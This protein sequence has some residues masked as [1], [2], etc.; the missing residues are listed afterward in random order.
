MVDA[1]APTTRYEATMLLLAGELG[2][3]AADGPPDGSHLTTNDGKLVNIRLEKLT[4][5]RAIRSVGPE[6]IRH[7][8]SSSGSRFAVREELR[9][10]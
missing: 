4:K 8:C 5:R 10:C 1:T 7:G 3:C 6:R 2:S 9:L